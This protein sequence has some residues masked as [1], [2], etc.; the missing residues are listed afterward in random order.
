MTDDEDPIKQVLRLEKMSTNWSIHILRQKY[1]KPTKKSQISP[2]IY[3]LFI[4]YGIY[5]YYDCI[6]FN[7]KPQEDVKDFYRFKENLQ[8]LYGDS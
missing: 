5:D 3:P 7:C 8:W 1:R 4:F 6:E 2:I